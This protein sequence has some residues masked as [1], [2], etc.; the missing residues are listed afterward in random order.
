[1]LLYYYIYSQGYINI[2][3]LL[4]KC[5]FFSSVFYF[6]DTNEIQISIFI[7]IERECERDEAARR[8]LG[9]GFRKIEIASIWIA[10]VSFDRSTLHIYGRLKRKTNTRN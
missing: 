7:E 8:K 1:M 4:F 2:K 10:N 5:K 6:L 9:K 3:A